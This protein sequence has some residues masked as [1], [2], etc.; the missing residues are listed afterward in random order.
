M[1]MCFD[2]FF[3]FWLVCDFVYVWFGSSVSGGKPDVA[4]TRKRVAVQ[5][6]EAWDFVAFFV[7]DD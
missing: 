7:L 2:L 5:G 3:A 4:I 6:S 1:R